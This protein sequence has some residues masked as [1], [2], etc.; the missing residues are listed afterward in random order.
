MSGP[1]LPDGVGFA[2]AVPPSWW[3]LDVDPATRESGLQ[4]LLE[5]QVR[6]VPEL[7][8]HRTALARLLCEQAD[9][10][11]SAGASYCASMVEPTEDGPITASV[12]VLV[13]P[14]PTSALGGSV[15]ALLAPLTP[16]PATGPDDPWRTVEIVEVP[17]A[18]RAGRSFGVH[19]VDLP[20]A[21]GQVRM[22]SLQTLV[23]LPGAR[24]L[25]L[26]CSS[27]VLPL[28]EELLELFEAISST[29]EVLADA[30]QEV[31]G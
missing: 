4:R 7:R 8:E 20:D 24:V 2:L 22:V 11:W 28:A 25:L 30:P 16:I 14:A 10:A 13:V 26:I 29:L 31:A 23:P 18:G 1:Q 27:P 17:G 12:A 9:A 3:E 19:D 5:E 21:A 6:D 15:E